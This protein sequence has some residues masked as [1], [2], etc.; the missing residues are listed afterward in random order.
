MKLY[1]LTV[2][3]FGPFREE[4]VF[5]F[6]G[7]KLYL[8]VGRNGAGKSSFFVDALSYVFYGKLYSDKLAEDIISGSAESCIVVA[9]TDKGTVSRYRDSGGTVLRIDDQPVAQSAVDALVGLEKDLFFSSVVFGQGFKGFIFFKDSERREFITKIGLSFID[10]YV[11]AAEEETDIAQS[12]T[13]AIE[14]RAEDVERDLNEKDIE[15]YNLE[16]A[17]QGFLRSQGRDEVEQ[18]LSVT[19]NKHKTYVEVLEKQESSLKDLQEKIDEASVDIVSCSS[20]LEKFEFDVNALRKSLRES[21]TSYDALNLRSN[22]PILPSLL[23]NRKDRVL[24]Q[25]QDDIK[26]IGAEL[27]ILDSQQR[28]LQESIRDKRRRLD[29]LEKD[30][31]VINEKMSMQ[32]S[33]I[34][35]MENRISELTA[36][37]K[38]I[39]NLKSNPY[40]K[41]IAD[42]KNEVKAIE[43][44]SNITVY[45]LKV[46]Q[47]TLSASKT[48]L[49]ELRKKKGELFN[50]ILGQ[51]SPLA[52]SYLRFLTGG[53]YGVKIEASTK[54]TDK[55]ISDKFSVRII[56]DYGE[57]SICRLSG[58]EM[59]IVALACN[60]ALIQALSAYLA[61]DFNFIV[62]DEVFVNMDV[63]HKGR[64]V[65]VLEMIARETGKAIVMLTPEDTFSE[66]TDGNGFIRVMIENGGIK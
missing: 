51:L 12:N 65:E 63:I 50:G 19:K 33:R 34:S 18:E 42:K 26:R 39:D 45:S 57:I 21:E 20:K 9:K 25:L 16:M 36:E 48:V 31:A 46:A 15:L 56:Q 61:A 28:I 14:Q 10:R 54:I 38:S 11:Q 27:K 4:T 43:T 32:R 37:L 41:L 2:K 7:G 35:S 29:V 1:E 47:N 44:E 13:V 30:K 22:C 66:Y 17:E 3:G 49:E 40:K 5:K 52:N 64:V 6:D 60:M 8:V 53:K 58:G 24:D 23:C 62:L 55:R 59:N